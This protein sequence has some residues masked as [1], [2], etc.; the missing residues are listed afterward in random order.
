MLPK[1]QKRQGISGHVI[2][3]ACNEQLS[4]L[5]CGC[6]S[7]HMILYGADGASV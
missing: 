1:L 3:C 2:L 5:I 4:G 7:E 6:K